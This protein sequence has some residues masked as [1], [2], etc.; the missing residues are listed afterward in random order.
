[1]FQD[2]H[3]GT[4]KS[5]IQERNPDP[6]ARL[7]IEVPEVE[8][9]ET[10]YVYIYMENMEIWDEIWLGSLEMYEDDNLP[11]FSKIGESFKL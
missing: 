3:L 8:I 1:M 10:G 2:N 11:L 6:P 9:V 4:L 7:E 5:P